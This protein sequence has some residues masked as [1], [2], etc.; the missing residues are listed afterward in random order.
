MVFFLHGIFL[1]PP[2]WDKLLKKIRADPESFIYDDGGWKSF[3]DEPEGEEEGTQSEEDSAYESADL[4]MEE[5]ED[6]DDEDN[7][8]IRLI[9]LFCHFHIIQ[10]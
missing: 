1:K 8:R 3:A 7:S 2:P 6:D 10:I 9:Y 4:Q 5:G